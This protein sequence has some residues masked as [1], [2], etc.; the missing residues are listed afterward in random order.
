MSARSSPGVL[1]VV[2]LLCEFQRQTGPH[3][4]LLFTHTEF[5]EGGGKPHPRPNE[6]Y[7]GPE[8]GDD[9]DEVSRER[10]EA[11]G[12]EAADGRHAA[13]APGGLNSPSPGGQI[14][15]RDRCRRHAFTRSGCYNNG[16]RGVV[17][18]GKQRALKG[19]GFR[20]RTIKAPH[21]EKTGP[22]TENRI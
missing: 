21:G 2:L 11:S 20:A 19:S 17:V 18:R 4:V 12:D 10:E 7:P 15:F 14:D 9:D 3:V 22:R 6:A 16:R 8:Y 13:T 5:R 1:A